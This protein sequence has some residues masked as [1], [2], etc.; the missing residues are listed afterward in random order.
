ML[1]G[2]TRDVAGARPADTFGIWFRRKGRI[3]HTGLVDEVRGSVMLTVEA[4][5]NSNAAVGSSADRDGEG[6]RRKRRF[7]SQVHSTRD[8]VS[9]PAKQ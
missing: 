2:G 6:I 9:K 8:W 4:N 1:S 3:A 7:L 5:T